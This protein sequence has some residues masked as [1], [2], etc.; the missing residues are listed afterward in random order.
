MPLKSHLS[1]QYLYTSTG[2]PV[3]EP[4]HM[5]YVPSLFAYEPSLAEAVIRQKIEHQEEAGRRRQL[6]PKN[7]QWRHRRTT[8]AEAFMFTTAETHSNSSTQTPVLVHSDASTQIAGTG[9]MDAATETPH[10]GF[11]DASTQAGESI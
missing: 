6:L 8:A 10:V 5:D 7:K 3:N 1:Y 4:S 11:I 2:K 9:M